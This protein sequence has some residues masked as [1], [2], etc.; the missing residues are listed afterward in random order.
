MQSTDGPSG[1]VPILTHPAL[2]VAAAAA[3]TNGTR[4]V[5]TVLH[6]FARGVL[7]AC[8]ERW[9]RLGPTQASCSWCPDR[10]ERGGWWPWPRV[11]GVR[12][13]CGGGWLTCK[14]GSVAFSPQAWPPQA[15][16]PHHTHRGTTKTREAVTSTSSWA[17][18]CCYTSIVAC[19]STTTF[20][21]T[22]LRGH[23]EAKV[24][25]RACTLH[26]IT[27]CG[28]LSRKI[29]RPWAL[30][31]HTSWKF[32][33]VGKPK[34]LLCRNKTWLLRR[35]LLVWRVSIGTGWILVFGSWIPA[36]STLPVLNKKSVWQATFQKF[37]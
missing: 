9:R 30:G 16:T 29:G 26:K 6:S 32:M 11:H 33:N 15:R 31:N 24:S 34:T 36:C 18:T 12:R 27:H 14:V 1:S 25:A 3:G 17:C 13:L 21:W 4:T 2:A 8:E 5:C 10:T 28:K 20:L 37:S 19:L 35:S 7:G 22:L 23:R